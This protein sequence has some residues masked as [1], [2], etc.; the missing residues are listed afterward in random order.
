MVTFREGDTIHLNYE[1]V[2]FE[3]NLV[4]DDC[5]LKSKYDQRSYNRC[6]KLVIKNINSKYLVSIK[7]T[8]MITID[9]SDIQLLKLSSS[10]VTLSNTNIEYIF[11]HNIA[12]IEC[13]FLV[14]CTVHDAIKFKFIKG[15]FLQNTKITRI[16]GVYIDRLRIAM[17]RSTIFSAMCY[18]NM[19][20]TDY[21][22]CVTNS[23]NLRNT[24]II[25]RISSKNNT[26]ESL[27]DTEAIRYMY[28]SVI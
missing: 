1:G 24:N 23:M 5:F 19:F 6:T 16:C 4:I 28:S 20:D 26:I 10:T 21:K 3:S 12:K 17:K 2:K 15:L 27:Y 9:E 14:N 11:F 13:L 25:T 22:D 18:I 7:T 8:K